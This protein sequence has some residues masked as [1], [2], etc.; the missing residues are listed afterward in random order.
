MDAPPTA[1]NSVY[2][3]VNRLRRVVEA[4]NSLNDGA[5]LLVSDRA[6]YALMLPL[7][8]VD[9]HSFESRLRGA[10]HHRSAG[11]PD[12]AIA[13][14]DAA[15]ALWEGTAYSGAPG[16]FAQAERDRLTE[17][18]LTAI[19]ERAELLL[20][21]GD[22]TEVLG[23]LMPLARRYPLRERLCHL[24]MLCCV[25]LG[26]QVDA[27]DTY[28]RLR[29]KLADEVGIEP[30]EQLQRLYTQ[31][32][33][34][35]TGRPAEYDDTLGEPLLTTGSLSAGSPPCVGREHELRSL[36]G[37]VEED[38]RSGRV[39]VTVLTGLAGIGKTALAVRL[40]QELSR[41]RPHETIRIDLA[42]F[43]T[44]KP[45]T[46]DEALDRL[47]TALGADAPPGT[48]VDYKSAMCRAV[49]ARRRI[50][51]I[52][53]DAASTAQVRPLLPD[54]PSCTVVIT[55]RQ[56]LSALTSRDGIHRL[57]VGELPVDDAVTL[58]R[59]VAGPAVER[60]ADE[61]AVQGVVA[62]C[63]GLPH[64]LRAA[65]ARLGG[66][67]PFVPGIVRIGRSAECAGRDAQAEGLRS[68]DPLFHRSWLALPGHAARMFTALGRHSRPVFTLGE[69]VALTCLDR[70]EVLR[71]LSALVEASMLQSMA[72]GRYRMHPLLFAYA[73][74]TVSGAACAPLRA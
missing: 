37:A 66:A 23:E 45:L 7:D 74:K 71:G 62:S 26:R 27:L 17:L 12:R 29:M 47:L 33:K 30:G 22:Y 73:A 69:V 48:A 46:P 21:R 20:G 72:S 1:V 40:G 36:V 52:L 38:G 58:F 63:G 13:E 70:D 6:G 43:R 51:L 67:D 8:R 31:I 34:P 50:F 9:Q 16:P 56:R 2:T 18:R 53:D 41:R 11:A 54:S 4:Q 32:I 61:R 55:S 44:R 60:L 59:R 39:S 64:A 25:A 42:G 68:L 24:L 28:H 65:A 5:R 57:T 15:L 49:M 35:G 3:Y 19:E 10:R 14:L